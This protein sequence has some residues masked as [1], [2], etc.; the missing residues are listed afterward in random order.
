[1]SRLELGKTAWEFPS[2]NGGIDYVNDPSSA[3]FSDAPIPKLVREIIQNALDAKHSGS[4]PV[5]VEFTE[6]SVRRAL[7]GG[8]S[9]ERHI[10]ACLRRA[11]RDGRP[12][13][14]VAYETALDTVRKERIRCLKIQDSGTV[15]LDDARWNALVVQEG[16]VSK[17]G[18]SPGGSYGIGKNAALNVSDLQ[19]VFYSTRYVARRKGRVEKM[20]GKATLMGHEDPQGSG[21]QLQ[22]IG[23]YAEP[24]G[25]PL[26]GMDI[27]SFFRLDKMGTGVF[28][29]G[30]SPRSANW[31]DEM[32]SAVIK[33]FFHAI[34]NRQ[35]VVK[36]A[37]EDTDRPV[38]IDYATIDSLF[39]SQDARSWEAY[40]YKAVRDVQGKSTPPGLSPLGSL[41]VH[42]IFED[43]APRR[44]ALVNHNGMLI[45][46][47]KDLRI[48]P[49]SPRAR[50]VWP[51]FAAVAIPETEKGDRW[52][53]SMENPSHDSLSTAQLPTEAKRR[54]ADKLFKNIRVAISRMIED[55]ADLETYGQES[56]IDELARVLADVGTGSDRMLATTELTPKTT[57]YP[58][59]DE[60]VDDEFF[61]DESKDETPDDPGEDRGGKPTSENVPDPHKPG[62]EPKNGLEPRLKPRNAR[63]IP[64]SSAE[65]VIA[66]D[67]PGVSKEKMRLSLTPAGADRDARL[68]ERLRIIEAQAIS[69][70]DGEIGVE[71]GQI[72]L[73][74]ASVGRLSVRVFVDG[75][76]QRT[77]LKVI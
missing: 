39:D 12:G 68:E 30:F 21:E 38:R 69:G 17:L 41:S 28:V 32:S 10:D 13:A 26:M 11:E 27:P 54:K 35:L 25:S 63:V 75:D 73:T 42:I 6:T 55:M 47:S 7:I 5:V 70:V 36:I 52:L 46:D 64:I 16:A 19:T 48:N 61:G 59:D 44:T 67:S 33:N 58:E 29:M 60:Q 71:D 18:G 56:N 65:A 3:Y 40:Y 22:H 31:V 1:M 24:D 14:K 57:G 74:P 50:S 76:M 49:I 9:L 51:D 53:R 15:G 8:E 23:F 34:S 66:F 43:S 62:E 77:A 72:T 45:A 2:R 4:D 20:Q 37:A